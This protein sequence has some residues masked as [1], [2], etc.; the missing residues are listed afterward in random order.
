MITSLAL[1]QDQTPTTEAPPVLGYGS[2]VT[3]SID[4]SNPRNAWPLEISSLD[5][6]SIRVERS[7]GNLLPD[8][9]LRD[10]NG[11]QVAQS[12]GTDNTGAAAEIDN[13]TL[14][15]TGTY[16][17]LVQRVDFETGLTSGEYSLAVTLL[18]SGE[19]S[20][21]NSTPIGPLEYNTYIEDRI[22]AEHWLHQY[23]FTASGAD[24]IQVTGTRNAG[25]LM[26]EVEV[27]DRDGNSLNTGYDNNTGDSAS[28]T[29]DLPQAGQYTVIM[30]RARRFDGM[31]TGTYRLKLDLL[32]AG[33][34]SPALDQIAGSIE[35]DKPL[36]GQLVDGQWYQD[37]TLTVDAGDVITITDARPLDAAAGAG[38]L[39]PEV[40]LLGGSDQ[41][42]RHGYVDDSGAMAII[43]HYQLEAP[44]EYILR[45]MR[46][47]QKDGPTSGSYVLT[48]TLNG[49]G[50]GSPGTH[51]KRG[52]GGAR[53][54]GRRRNHRRQMDQHL[55]FQR[56]CRPGV[57]YSGGTHRWHVHPACRDPGRQRP[58]ALFRLS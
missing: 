46:E 1:A 21:A 40:V 7:G 53:H 3:G 47:G 33:E 16:Q 18:A 39:R 22:T 27:R 12:Y 11:D 44:G 30:T 19:D 26:P 58:I 24:H 17:V 43:D 55:E 31:T 42:L 28:L 23:T 20:Q 49:S 8:L 52:Y 29:Y 4:N 9:I 13:V 14:T 36:V 50:P 5:R 41:E 45:A 6:I 15:R 38:N 32:G 37:W 10:P 34:G 51:G 48:V 35:Y 2:P 54:P 56:H 25:T 57:G